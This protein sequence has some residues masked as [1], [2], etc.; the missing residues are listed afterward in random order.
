MTCL[1]LLL[2]V[3]PLSAS[4]GS[5]NI[6]VG[7]GESIQAAIN[8][9]NS[10]DVI[11]VKSGTYHEDLVIDKQ[12]TLRGVDSGDGRPLFE[13]KGSNGEITLLEDGITFEGFRLNGFGIDVISDGNIVRNNVIRKSWIGIGLYGSEN[14]N[15]SHND[16]ECEGIWGP[17][18]ISLYQS[19]RNVFFKND[20]KSRGFMGAGIF[21]NR[22]EDN[23]IKDNRLRGGWLG[24][25][26]HLMEST[27]NF[28]VGNYA[29]DLSWMGRGIFLYL[30]NDN[31]VKGNNATGGSSACSVA[32]MWSNNNTIVQNN[33]TNNVDSGIKIHHSRGNV[34]YLNNF[35]KNRHDPLLGNSTSSWSSPEPIFYQYGGNNFTSRL[36][37]FWSGYSGSDAEG[38]GIGDAPRRFEGGEDKFP[39]MDRCENYYCK[40]EVPKKIFGPA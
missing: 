10:G 5:A 32:I 30:S 17:F 21:L 20:V 31:F 6:T 22:C 38:D 12:L 36:G 9:A 34:V 14:N 3:A 26:I 1:A 35:D 25:G 24:N 37:N 19:H 7:P 13:A 8:D 4:A 29:E 27:N 2:F 16:I 39:L 15:I 33:L 28:I 40:V 18:G 11:E 23:I